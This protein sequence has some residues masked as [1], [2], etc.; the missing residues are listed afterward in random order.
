VAQTSN[1]PAHSKPEPDPSAHPD[2]GWLEGRCPLR[3]VADRLRGDLEDPEKLRALLFLATVWVG[4]E[5]RCRATAAPIRS[6][7][8]EPI[9]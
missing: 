6:I 3:V 9:G 7:G 4:R 8:A 2:A 5:R 1:R